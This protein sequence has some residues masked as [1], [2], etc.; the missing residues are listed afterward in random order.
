M[1][2]RFLTLVLTLLTAVQAAWSWS[3]AGTSTSPY[4][5]ESNED[6]QTLSSNV[7]NG[8]S[9]DDIFFR[10]AVDIDAGSMSVGTA[11][12]PFAGIFDG[13]GHTLTYT[14][15]SQTGGAIVFSEA[16]CAPFAY[17][18]G[19]SIRHLHTRGEIFS[20]HQYA[21]GVVG[22]VVGEDI[23]TLLDCSSEMA[24][25][26]QHSG[27]NDA[28]GG[29]VGAVN[30]G[31]LTLLDSSFTGTI[32][33]SGTVGG[34]VGWSNVPVTMSFCMVSPERTV[35]AT[36]ANGK[37][38][39]RMAGGVELTLTDCFYTLPI[40]SNDQGTGVFKRI[41]V[42]EGCTI[43]YLSEPSITFGREK[44]YTSGTE[45]ELTAP[46][47]VEFDHWMSINGD[48]GIFISDPWTKNGRHKVYDVIGTD[49]IYISTISHE[50][51]LQ[52]NVY[53]VEYRYLSSVDY[54][55]YL[56]RET[57]TKKG[58]QLD[59]DGY[60]FM[61]DSNDTKNFITAV[62]GCDNSDAAFNSTISEGWYWSDSEFTGT[63]I[64]ND[65]VADTWDHTHLAVIAPR[66]F[67]DVTALKKV[68]FMSDRDMALVK[69]S[70]TPL[71]LV[72]DVQAFSGCTGMTELVMMYKNE[73]TDKWE[74]ITPE[75]NLVIADN[76]FEGSGCQIVVDKDVYQTFLS[77]E[78]WAALQNRMGI[79]MATNADFMVDGAVYSY[80]RNSSGDPVKNNAAGHNTIT[81]VLNT[82][83]ANFQNFTI[84]D[85]LAEQ[86]KKNIW[87]TQIIGIDDSGLTDGKMIIRNDPGTYYNYKNIAIGAEAFAGNENLKSIEFAQVNG[88]RN[89]YSDMKMVIQNGAF[90]GCKNLKE[91][92]M[93]YWCED[94]DD[95]WEA[96][97]PE[98]VI[99]GNNIFGKVT[100]EDLSYVTE[101]NFDSYYGIPRDFKILVSPS[102]YQDFISDPNW[103][104]YSAYIEPVD[105][106]LSN[107]DDFTIG[108]ATGIKYNYITSPGGIHQ[109]S[110][111]VSQDV[112]WWT[113]PRIIAE[114]AL[115]AATMGAWGASSGAEAV[116]DPALQAT[117]E[118]ATTAFNTETAAIETIRHLY[119][120]MPR[121]LQGTTSTAEVMQYLASRSVDD[122]LDHLLEDEIAS[123]VKQG[124]LTQVTKASGAV[125]SEFLT[126]ASE[127]AVR[128]WLMRLMFMPGGDISTTWLK[129]RL[130]NQAVFKTAM[131]AAAA[132][133]TAAAEQALLTNSS[134]AALQL[135]A[136]ITG[137]FA[138]ASTLSGMMASWAWGGSGNYDG[139]A[140]RKGMRENIIANMHQVALLGG[141]YVITTPTKNLLYHTYIKSVDDNVV[142]AVIYAGTDKGQGKNS[143]AR[144][145]TFAKKAF[146]DHKN[147]K[148]V[149]FYENNV[150]TNEAIPMLL[151]IPDSAFIGC[152]NLE[153]F[154]MILKTKD[155]GTQALGPENFILAGNHV[156]EGVDTLKFKIIIPEE[157]REDFLNSASWSPLKR[158]FVYAPTEPKSALEEY[159]GKYAYVYE[160]GSV[161]KVHKVLGHKIEHTIVIGEA[162]NGFMTKHQGALKLCNDI[163]SWNNYQL[164]AVRRKAFFGNQNLR[165]VN[166]TDLFGKGAFGDVY[167]GLDVVLQDSC[168]ADCQNLKSLDMLY[169]VTD[170]TNYI[171]PIKPTEVKLGRG[172]LDGTTAI[173]KM[174]PRQVEWFVNDS[175]WA[176]YKDRF[177]GCIIQPADDEVRKALKD[178]AYYDTAHEGY[179]DKYWTDYI[180]LYAIKTGT[181]GFDWLSGKMQ[182][183]DIRSFTDFKYFENVGLDYIGC[184]WFG[185]CK[186]LSSIV[187]PS[188]I[189]QIRDRA[190][191]NCSSLKEIE[192]PASVSRIEAEAFAG[193]TSLLSIRVHGT[194]PAQLGDAGIFTKNEG[195]KIYVPA[196]SV[197]AYKAAWEEYKDYIVSDQTF[198]TRKVITVTEVG[199]L[200]EKLHLTLEKQHSK[201]RY[202][203]GNY[204]VL[205][206]LT[207]TGP[208]NGEDLSVIRHLAG[209]DAYDSDPTDG[210]LRYLNMWNVTIKRDDENS[211]NGN[212]FDEYIDADN[213]VP[214]YLFE[215]CTAIETVIFPKAATYIGENIFEDASSMRRVCVGKSTTE[216]ECDI[217][218]NLKGIEELV[219]LTDEPATST[220]GDPW[221]ADI[222]T[223]FVKKSQLGDYLGHPYLTKRSSQ[224]F[225]PFE[226]DA[227]M[228]AMAAKGH[229]FSAEYTEL[230]SLEGIFEGND[231]LKKFDD[232]FLF[233]NVHRFDRTFNNCMNLESVILPDSV[234]YIGADAFSGCTN[235]STIRL[236]CDNVP[237][238]AQDAFATQVREFP[239]TFS[240]YVPKDL[241]KLYRSTWTQYAEYINPDTRSYSDDDI[242]TIRV[243]EANT[244][245]EKL[246]LTTTKEV[247]FIGKTYINSLRGDYSHIRKLKIIG[248]I[249]G[250]D[251]SVIR[252][253][254]GFCPWT[255]D[256]NRMAP[257]EYLDLY[258]ADVVASEYDV[259]PDVVTTR[260]TYVYRYNTL[261]AY[262]FLQCYNLKTLILPQTLVEVDG[263][264]LQQCENLETLVIGDNLETFNWDA[265]NDD[266]HLTRL[267]ILAKKKL[268]I[269]NDFPIWRELC[270]NYNPTFDAFYVRPSLYQTYIDDPAYT[271]D[272]WQ[273]TNNISRGAFDDDESFCAF[274]S[275]AAATE[276]DLATV[277]SVDGW[278]D[279]HSDMRNLTPLKY[280]SISNFRTRDMHL[281]RNIEQ[282]ALP[283]TFKDFTYDSNNENSRLFAYMPALQY[284]DMSLC[285]SAIVKASWKGDAKQKLGICADALLY[286]PATYGETNEHN[287]VWGS[288]ADFQNNYFDLC[289]QRD[290][291]VPYAFTSRHITST[292]KLA[293]RTGDALSKYTICV[294][295]SMPVPADA[296]AY[297]LDGFDNG[298][299][300]FRQ[301]TT[302][303]EA[304]TPYLLI[305][306]DKEVSL[307]SDTEQRI[308]AKAE[309]VTAV[310]QNQV[311]VSMYTMRGTLSEISNTQANKLGAL[312]LQADNKWYPVPAD[313]P[314]AN[315]P[316][317]RTYVLLN[318]TLMEP[319]AVGMT[320]IDGDT[321]GIDTIRTIDTDGAERYY[322][323]SGRQLNGRP[324]R[325]VYIYK[326][327]KYVAK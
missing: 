294:P 327:K 156:F 14:G 150:S 88:D 254:A 24:I 221:E 171:S 230:E 76:A 326:G 112:S 300:S 50:A 248:P 257:L 159:G 37:T 191:K 39:A 240:I 317:F 95:H 241:C 151:T 79:Y 58:Y 322:D 167:T 131:D 115:Y 103:M 253:L 199:Q 303:L 290:Y 46:D 27:S 53:G 183:K 4:L 206:S 72:I 60:L 44:Y 35:Y 212:G 178:M 113:A 124:I 315:I 87:Y 143:S 82:W 179:D 120:L 216:Y 185:D 251:L 274:A 13:D 65:I 73:S 261:P 259:A 117:L 109:T 114:I 142:D 107:K 5:L 30:T 297:K 62:V 175:T 217:L 61:Y 160:S 231:D 187:L 83:N 222:A 123:L 292:R 138:G 278:F 70:N 158:F 213:K 225:A 299:L 287:V 146:R 144:T 105:F 80:L 96:L 139:D 224:I 155:N 6:W 75:T 41:A 275:H 121:V 71:D 264:A 323:I 118:A 196:E 8:D 157:R 111:T 174:M 214:D 277:Y 94:G 233:H 271:R 47:G 307:S 284:I 140:L 205:D 293:P 16:L 184:D 34:L 208:L 190:F 129:L 56:S 219:F 104:P 252:Y 165:V 239:N 98:N 186:K 305:V 172:V 306:D 99:P 77:D 238:L 59:S 236:A 38:F 235:L 304:N 132:Q 78:A 314:V 242:I 211:Y 309:A 134:N 101:E 319:E 54:H 260:T 137:S 51:K 266:A 192:I 301:V 273:K 116:V 223:V 67:K 12:T 202:V 69:N 291:S 164:D 269:S 312:V 262:S 141:G 11:E 324:E 200:A 298:I 310:G 148:T 23:T 9:Y 249:S 325:G 10:M 166:F 204:G 193:C 130:A 68:V 226:D 22:M 255:N 48:N 229:F 245:A 265:L 92:R 152:T 161:Q 295:F 316:A 52:R 126:E 182:G 136:S 228:E 318:G 286:V 31:G 45:I 19:A 276:D 267:Y 106:D 149:S 1:K 84:Y 42:P 197:E 163:G 55:L 232:L 288:Y 43:T 195:L 86:D 74:V 28:A 81:S 311:D 40:G 15:G 145:T 246:G 93:F 125:V 108:D 169:L 258:E 36:A 220:W 320:L 207:I 85:V 102:R 2:T 302:T 263:R 147:L 234:S 237:E 256:R 3:G 194:K 272:S 210:K 17:V 32:S 122:I 25:T 135:T 321:D 21:A 33:V 97:G 181:H 128:G 20:S 26:T 91:I 64:F 66:A 170:G 173:I 7:G 63:I 154:S 89:S 203:H 90:K 153:S 243:E 282:I 279:L 110:Q 201:V 250:A 49:S 247:P 127:E 29:L 209:A 289:D 218:Q 244:L 188:T 296:R 270:N 215:N 100:P 313:T 18:S 198:E 281:L 189:G 283:A 308:L 168:F 227:V 176:Q 180:D 162:E 268:K 119:S 280:T 285:D 133:V 57:C 177:V